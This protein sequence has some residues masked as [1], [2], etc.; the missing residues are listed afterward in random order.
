MQ[1]QAQQPASMI[2]EWGYQAYLSTGDTTH[3]F[4]QVQY[5]SP[6][7]L[8]S[9]GVNSEGTTATARLE[10]QGALSFVDRGLFAS[11]T[12]FDSFAIVDTSPIPHVHV[13]QEN[14]DVGS[15][16][17]AGRL[18]VP[19]MR[20]FD[21]NHIAIVA[22]DIPMDS[23]VEDTTREVRPQDRS[24]VVIHFA[25][26]VTHGALLRL[27]DETGETIQLGS[28][29]TLRATG[30]TVPVGYDGNAYVEGLSPRNEVLV[31]R[32][33]GHRCTV[34]FNYRPVPGDIPMIGPLRCMEPKL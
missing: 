21:L 31:E 11:N 29:A 19:D 25:G 12:I 16:N 27:V 33:D 24:G 2:G 28:T 26:K 20:S 13:L 10:A 9:A 8:F 17:S 1:V 18:L 5:K 23:S 6:W 14:R 30:V 34:V 7:G 4:A 3:G 22:T 32:M 15:T